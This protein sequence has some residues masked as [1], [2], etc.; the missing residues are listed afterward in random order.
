MNS[1][2]GG[3]MSHRS[4]F[5]NSI[6]TFRRDFP[7]IVLA[8]SPKNA[9]STGLKRIKVLYEHHSKQH[10]FAVKPIGTYFSMNFKLQLVV[11]AATLASC[12]SGAALDIFSPPIIQP[13]A[14]TVW[15]AGTFHNVRY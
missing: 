14:A 15:K 11:V 8:A 2:F 10:S 1:S 7:L 13:D 12:V 6:T 3:V 9:R 5:P 4:S